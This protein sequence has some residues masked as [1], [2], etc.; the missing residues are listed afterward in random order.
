MDRQPRDFIW[1]VRI[2]SSIARSRRSGRTRGLQMHL[3]P[4]QG[5]N[6]LLLAS[7]SAPGREA[8]RLF[9]DISLFDEAQHLSAL[10]RGDVEGVEGGLE[11]T[12]KALP[13]ALVDAHPTVRGRH[14]STDVIE[15]AA[16]AGA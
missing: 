4:S 8:V 14:V 13:I 12:Y 11:M 3:A 16:R 6:D 7:G 1:M 15:W 5:E 9:D 10:C 2:F